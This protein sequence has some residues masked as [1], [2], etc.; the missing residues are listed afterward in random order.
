MSD[1]LCNLIVPGAA[2]SGTSTLHALLDQHPDICMSRAKEPHYFSK[3]QNYRLGP[4]KH[5][6]IFD[7]ESKT[8]A[9]YYGESSTGYLPWPK[10]IERIRAD[11]ADPMIIIIL[12][13]P[14]ERAFSHYRWRYRLGL[15]KRPL[16][17]ALKHDGDDYDPARPDRYGYM[18]YLQ[19]SRYSVF[20]PLW[21]ETF[22][23]DK[24]K[25]VP[26]ERLASD[27]RGLMKELFRFLDLS[28]I[29]LDP[30]LR[31]NT[32]EKLQRK[33]L[34]RHPLSFILPQRI[35]RSA[36][37]QKVKQRIGKRLAPVPP[38]KLSIK[39][40]KYL[41]EVLASDVSWYDALFNS[42]D[43]PNSIAASTYI[44]NA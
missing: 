30:K 42:G 1:H 4:A 38:R 10:A 26:F 2:K 7:C 32:T 18:S 22:G 20:C 14:V 27:P 13:H 16:L 3:D 29:D 11:L 37:F 39:E 24:V 43:V 19:F 8:A 41:N 28:D 12:R 6:A 34:R 23:A 5:N 31:V 44:S 17:P 25:L 21:I 35:R 9:Q 15:E 40:R 33:Q 36:P